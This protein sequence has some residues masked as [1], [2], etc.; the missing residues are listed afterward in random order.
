MLV[1]ISHVIP[2]IFSTPTKPWCCFLHVPE[3]PHNML[4][5][6]QLC[7]NNNCSVAFDSTSVHFRDNTTG[8]VLLP[9]PSV[10]NV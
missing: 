3:V 7:S 4:S 8:D 2:S 6:M 5:I 9:A 1:R 10:D